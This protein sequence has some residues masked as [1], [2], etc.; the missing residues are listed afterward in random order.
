MAEPARAYAFGAFRLVPARRA[1]Y[2]DGKEIDIRSRPFDLLLAL[3][4]R[5]ERVVSKDELL[6]LVWQGRIVEEGNL[7]VHI[8]SLRKRLGDGVIA[9]IPGRGYRF[10]A[11]AEVELEPPVPSPKPPVSSN[12]LPRPLSRLIGRQEDVAAVSDRLQQYPLVTI[13]GP[14]GIGKT[15]VAIATAERIRG[16][17]PDGVWFA[18]L[19]PI[20]TPATVPMALCSMLGVEVSSSDAVHE[21]SRAL[22]EKRALLILDCCEHLLDAVAA[23]AE[24]LLRA[25]PALA[26][27]ATSREPLRSEGE[28]L[29]RLGPLLAAPPEADIRAEDVRGYPAAEMFIERATAA[30]AAFALS[31]SQTTTLMAICRRLDGI[32][33]AIELAAARLPTLGLEHLAARLDDRF[34]FLTDGRRT[35]LPRHQT[36]RA[37]LDWSY[38]TLSESEIVVLRRLAS[39]SGSFTLEAAEAVAASEDVPAAV[40]V[41]RVSNLVA[42]SLIVREQF[43]DAVRYRL[44]DTTRDYV[45]EKLRDSD[46]WRLVSCRHAQFYR[47]LLDRAQSEWSRRTT[48]DWLAIYLRE[49]DNIRAGLDWALSEDG[50]PALAVSL[51]SAA[52]VLLYD[53]GLLETCRDIADR[54]LSAIAHAPARNQR[55]EMRL[56]AALGACLVYVQGPGEA[57]HGA[58]ATTLDI[59]TSI[60]DTDHQARALWG[61]WNAAIY[62]GTPRTAMGHAQQYRQL[63]EEREDAA[64]LL[65]YRQIGITQHHLGQQVAAQSNLEHIVRRYARDRHRWQTFG[66]RID[67]GIVGR[68]NLARV[69]WLRGQCRQAKRMVDGAV[70]DA[71]AYGH[72]MTLQ[73]T[74]IEAA[75]P[76]ALLEDDLARAQRFLS[77]L[78]DRERSR[79]FYIWEVCG[80]CFQAVWL[81]RSHGIAT[82]LPRVRTAI[83]ELRDCGYLAHLTFLLAE[84]ARA[85]I[86]SNERVEAAAVLEEGWQRYEVHGDGCFWPELLRLKGELARQEGSIE[87]AEDCLL[88]AMT[89]A[90]QQGAL[91][92]ELRAATQLARLR[93]QTGRPAAGIE[94]LQPIFRQF[95][96]EFETP[97]VK[98]AG[99]LLAQCA[100]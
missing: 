2:Q 49:V 46:E 63:V 76:L 87:A 36:L 92:W 82:A 4:E 25:C 48:A 33:L 28:S 56:Q 61:L 30:D 29:Y 93:C 31:N 66:F 94:V 95:N 16:H 73:Y 19:S 55:D 54:A 20:G 18:D 80:R 37:T 75:I 8:A 72:A 26:I 74:L 52:V 15:R 39:F 91:M 89:A 3:I 12:S 13:V 71:Q 64:A 58:W 90:R 23:V 96:D 53:V 43:G 78:L 97:D 84:L 22:A 83:G 5:R 44:L 9:T 88:T 10:V 67:H 69:L 27:L 21:L 59:A 45:R 1:L 77:A 34:N 100:G 35:A 42:K 40:V 41:E 79:R 38:Q 68:A 81:M 24:T 14:G 60:S 17:H 6:G 11:A 70:E 99:T 57:T 65:S 62:G 47:T 7:A 86:E 98:V 51:S 50:D 85:L 32:P